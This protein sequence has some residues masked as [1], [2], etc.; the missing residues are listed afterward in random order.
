MRP[1][2]EPVCGYGAF[3][4]QMYIRQARRM[5]GQYISPSM[6]YYRSSTG[7]TASVRELRH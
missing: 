4:Y 1:A 2:E 7:P 6:I 5:V 3:P